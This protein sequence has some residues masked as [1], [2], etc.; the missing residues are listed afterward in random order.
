MNEPTKI[1]N[2]KLVPRATPQSIDGASPSV[3]TRLAAVP[4][5]RAL[6]PDKQR[7]VA[8][9]MDNVISFISRPNAIAPEAKER[10]ELPSFVG[11]LIEG[12]FDAM[13]N[14]SQEQM[15]AY[16]ELIASVSKTADDFM[17]E[18]VTDAA[19]RDWLAELYPDSAGDDSSESDSSDSS[20]KL[21]LVGVARRRLAASRQQLLA[22]MVMLGINRIV[23]TDGRITAKATF[24]VRGVDAA[25]S[26]IRA[27]S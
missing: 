5:F 26:D 4:A 8:K 21:G 11:E 2:Q 25:R 14:A 24:D 16:G 6:P 15:R 20:A 9:N 3:R 22:R 12:V 17:R 23:V 18:N 27:E 19:A 10:T 7:D 1:P 13:V